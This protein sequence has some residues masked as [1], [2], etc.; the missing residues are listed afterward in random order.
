VV[1]EAIQDAIYT[2]PDHDDS[3][4]NVMGYILR[5]NVKQH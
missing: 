4:D 5:T 1:N 3:I 2:H